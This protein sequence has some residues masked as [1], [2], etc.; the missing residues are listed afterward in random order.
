MKFIDAYRLVMGELG[1]IVINWN[2]S[3]GEFL[4][5]DFLEQIWGDFPAPERLVCVGPATKAEWNRQIKL[6]VAQGMPMPA[7]PVGW[8][9]SKIVRARPT[10]APDRSH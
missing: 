8:K 1:F 6:L 7:P 4:P 3:T 5:G 9:F 10:N 2:P